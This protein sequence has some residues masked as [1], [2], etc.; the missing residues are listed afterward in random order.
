MPIAIVGLH[1][2]RQPQPR[3]DLPNGGLS[4]PTN[5][6]FSKLHDVPVTRPYAGTCRKGHMRAKDNRM[7]RHHYRNKFRFNLARRLHGIWFRSV[8]SAPAF[9][10]DGRPLGTFVTAC[11]QSRHSSI[12]T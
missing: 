8:Q 1:H 4:A 11:G 10:F 2:N 6:P 5:L 7:Q 12:T 3:C 9:G